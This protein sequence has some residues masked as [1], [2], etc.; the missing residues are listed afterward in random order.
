MGTAPT[1]HRNV[2]TKLRG[3]TS[4]ETMILI[5]PCAC[6][7]GIQRHYYVL[8]TRTTLHSD[9]FPLRQAIHRSQLFQFAM[10][11]DPRVQCIA[12]YIKILL[13]G[14]E[15]VFLRL[16]DEWSIEET[17]CSLRVGLSLVQ[18][19]RRQINSK[20]ADKIMSLYY[21]P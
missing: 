7:V 15:N 16:A 12:V 18:V 8:T 14:A 1:F 13:T 5:T 2:N 9:I 6:H 10:S 3:V 20:L 17:W 11:R 4:Q 19:I 21:C